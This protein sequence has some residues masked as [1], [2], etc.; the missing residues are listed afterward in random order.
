ML[1]IVKDLLTNNIGLKILSVLAAVVIWLV[2][3]SID[4]P[5]KTRTFTTNVVFE[6]TNVIT[7][8]GK[9]F[10]VLEESNVV[11]FH[12]TAKRSLVERLSASD[13]KATANFENVEIKEDGTAV[14]PIDIVSTRYSSNQVDINRK[15][16][17][18]KLALEDLKSNQFKVEVQI[19]G[20][21]AQGS[22]VGDV[23]VTPDV[24]TVSGPTSV[25]SQIVK[26]VATV[27]VS[28][29]F[30]DWT[31]D[32]VPVLYDSANNALD[33]SRLTISHETVNVQGEM[34]S[35]KELPI[36]YETNGELAEGYQQVSISCNPEKIIVKGQAEIL[37]ELTTITIPKE[38]LD[39]SNVTSTVEKE[40]DISTYL[41]EGVSLVDASHA[42]IKITLVIEQMEQREFNVP[43]ENIK[44]FNLPEGYE[45][46]YQGET[47]PVT[48]SGYASDLKNLKAEDIQLAIDASQVEPGTNTISLS[49][50]L[51]SG[52]ELVEG[53]DITINVVKKN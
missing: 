2:V 42:K 7:D 3:L 51:G 24:I 27:D 50:T 5:D 52:Y 37:N 10:E 30:E 9:N 12:V 6:N 11:S 14:V 33:T 46:E 21:P 40:I 35:V 17:N 31:E 45:I 38:A 29:R 26:V 22:A 18:V 36:A 41:P 20:S 34:L 8:M 1:K 32:V 48:L 19:T 39:F 4:D 16:K 44:I 28:G 25:I 53:T 23:T 47:V 15:N 49:A 43:V 13:F